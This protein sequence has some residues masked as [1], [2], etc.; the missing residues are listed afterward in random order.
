MSY[1]VYRNVDKKD[2]YDIIIRWSK[3]KRKKNNFFAD[4]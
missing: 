1:T 3:I 4:D 2:A